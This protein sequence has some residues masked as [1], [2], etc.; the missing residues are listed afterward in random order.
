MAG[1]RARERVALRR[2]MRK[3]AGWVDRGCVG[4][5]PPLPTHHPARIVH[6]LVGPA[7][8]VRELA[9]QRH[10]LL[11][12]GAVPPEPQRAAAE[13]R[14]ERRRV[15]LPQ[16]AVLWGEDLLGNIR[17]A[18]G[19]CAMRCT[20]RGG[21]CLEAGWAMAWGG[22]GGGWCVVGGALWVVG[23]RAIAEARD[24]RVGLAAALGVGGGE[25]A[26]VRE[27]GELASLGGALVRS[28]KCW[29]GGVRAEV[30]TAAAE[31]MVAEE[32]RPGLA[33]AVAA[34]VERPRTTRASAC[35]G[36]AG[37][38]AIFPGMAWEKSSFLVK[39]C[40]LKVPGAPSPG[41]KGRRSDGERGIM[42]RSAVLWSGAR[43]QRV[44]GPG[45]RRIMDFDKIRG[46]CC[47]CARGERA[48]RTQARKEKQ[49]HGESAGEEER[50]RL[51]AGAEIGSAAVEPPPT[52]SELVARP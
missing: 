34:R 29:E 38:R 11:E 2:R 50:E 9:P 5:A 31:G 22:W 43:S 3:P 47:E 19:A 14:E 4:C 12:R 52:P 26:G 23:W 7:P 10:R 17:K 28:R 49:K 39:H 20:F 25:R 16:P 45:G 13:E 8:L 37:R 27:L 33:A 6:P 18:P 40:S 48:A 36:A 35:A 30:S 1:V 44:A 51:P 24:V 46:N 42:R 15:E 21:L 32:E 41:A